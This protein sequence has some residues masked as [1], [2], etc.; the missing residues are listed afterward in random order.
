MAKFKIFLLLIVILS[1][2]GFYNPM[3]MVPPLVSKVVF[4]LS[5]LAIL[6]LGHKVHV[7]TQLKDF[8]VKSYNMI[9]AGMI[10]SLIM[11]WIFQNQ[12]FMVSAVAMLPY[13]LSY[14][15][16]A[17]ICKCNISE[18]FCYKLLFS[19]IVISIITYFVNLVTFPAM[20]FGGG[21]G[22]NVDNS[23]GMLRLG[24]RYIELIILGLYF[25][26]YNWLKFKKKKW[27]VAIAVCTVMIVL[28]LTRQVIAL[29][30][31]L[32][33]LY[34]F[35][36]MPWIKKLIFTGMIGFVVVYVVPEIPIY[37]AMVE[38][39]E[40]QKE[41]NETRDDPRIRCFNFYTDT[42]QTNEVTRIFGNGVPSI[43]NS[44]WGNQFEIKSRQEGAYPSDLGWIGFYWYF[45]LI[46]SL[47]V[48]S[49]FVR[50]AWKCRN[51]EKDYLTYYLIS[52]IL[53][54]VLSGP[55]LYSTQI[56]NT[57]LVV[58]LCYI[59]KNNYYAKNR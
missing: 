29:S 28:S 11:A 13:F 1:A 37:K 32:G 34:A 45:G 39:S 57:M 10:G 27:L 24:V 51:T 40:Q 41:M 12:S 9:F 8:P 19:L 33:C 15:S 59:P 18:S 55:V 58:Y 46:A 16:L 26:I 38:V 31:V 54:S 7:H 53:L 47:G 21:D 5:M 56:I 44:Q 2:A 48:L 4:Y 35:K 42:Y 3:G 6:F 52:I 30:A 43:G 17:A 25:S 49:M 23:R 50:A 20:F 14:L 36:H 22:E